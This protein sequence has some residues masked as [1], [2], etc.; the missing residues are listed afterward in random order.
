MGFWTFRG[1][2]NDLK[3]W[4]FWKNPVA[5]GCRRGSINSLIKPVFVKLGWSRQPADPQKRS[6]SG[7]PFFTKNTDFPCPIFSKNGPKSG[8][9]PWFWRFLKTHFFQKHVFW[10]L[11][12]PL[13]TGLID[14]CPLNFSRFGPKI[15][16]KWAKN[17]HFL[18][19]KH[20]KKCNFTGKFCTP[21]PKKW[22]HFLATFWPTF[23]STFDRIIFRISWNLFRIKPDFFKNPRYLKIGVQKRPPFFGPKMTHF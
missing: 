5:G 20:Q 13:F 23:W 4:S 18:A 1:P 21:C 6:K 15:D 11:F 3:K 17:G 7:T 16:Q 10:P 22:P 19:K 9:K 8:Q 2:K 14:F 12:W